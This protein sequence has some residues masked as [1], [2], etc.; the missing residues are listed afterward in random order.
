MEQ[1]LET[2]KQE[3]VKV[4]EGL[5]VPPPTPVTPHA[6]AAPSPALL[7]PKPAAHPDHGRMSQRLHQLSKPKRAAPF[8]DGRAASSSMASSLAAADFRAAAQSTR[9]SAR[10]VPAM[11][12][13]ARE[14]R[15]QCESSPPST[16]TSPSVT[17]A[18][19][20]SSRLAQLSTPKEKPPPEPKPVAF[21]PPPP[22]APR[23]GQPPPP[24]PPDAPRGHGRKSTLSPEQQMKLKDHGLAKPKGATPVELFR[25]TPPRTSAASGDLT[26]DSDAAAAQ[27]RQALKDLGRAL[28]QQTD[29]GQR[30][31]LVQV[32]QCLNNLLI[33]T[34]P[35]RAA[36]SS[37]S[38]HQQLR[39]TKE[40]QLQHALRLV[41]SLDA[42]LQRATAAREG[43]QEAAAVA[44]REA[45][46]DMHDAALNALAES[47]ERYTSGDSIGAG[48]GASDSASPAAATAGEGGDDA[49]SGGAASS[50]SLAGVAVRLNRL[51][52]HATK[53]ATA[54]T[55]FSSSGAALPSSS[56]YVSPTDASCGGL[57]PVQAAPASSTESSCLPHAATNESAASP[58]ADASPPPPPPRRSPRKSVAS[59]MDLPSSVNSAYRP[60]SDS[61]SAAAPVDAT[62]QAR[63]AP[64]RPDSVASGA[65]DVAAAGMP[66]SL[67]S[68]LA[69]LRTQLTAED[70][71][72]GAV[73]AQ[74]F[75]VR[76]PYGRRS[77]LFT[78]AGNGLGGTRAA[79]LL[80]P[81]IVVFSS[82]I[83]SA[84]WSLSSGRAGE[85]PARMT[86]AKE[87]KEASRR[88]WERLS[89]LKIASR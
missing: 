15:K 27:A 30:E 1:W 75:G 68:Q 39:Q 10:T 89:K 72:S 22:P 52:E 54:V 70:S 20:V 84:L 44:S 6:E 55:A 29:Q 2:V 14:A 85:A 81:L 48:S 66:Q 31:L 64:S 65:A 79:G 63:D 11:R 3:S 83:F 82:I 73:L 58:H 17:T 38:S 33:A 5:G 12:A 19:R 77:S 50:A 37:A 41:R 61:P 45:V 7:P 76:E 88:P 46:Q 36:L 9:M 74:R 47:L 69:H 42:A 56:T 13:S 40:Q 23:A 62:S 34:S 26:S 4:F 57:L 60:Q 51:W 43:A 18:A 87:L 25:T 80:I 32:T 28:R 35:D 78:G 59:S 24:P 8:P 16:P 86:P 53:T 21:P 67:R 71:T 49:A